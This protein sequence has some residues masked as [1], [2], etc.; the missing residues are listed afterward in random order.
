VVLEF[1]VSS[2]AVCCIWTS[3]SGI[4]SGS[5]LGTGAEVE[6]V[7]RDLS[8]GPPVSCSGTMFVMLYEYDVFS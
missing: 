4:C 8:T 6:R 3:A 5:L 1:C 2:C 7:L